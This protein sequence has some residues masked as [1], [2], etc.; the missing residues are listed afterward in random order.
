MVYSKEAKNVQSQCLPKAKNTKRGALVRLSSFQLLMKK[1][2]V[3]KSHNL[4]SLP[5]V[6]PP[7]SLH[8]V[9]SEVVG[10]Q[11]ADN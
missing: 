1:L 6:A 5:V 11:G 8:V 7:K 3:Q 2:C 10:I 4:S 9:L